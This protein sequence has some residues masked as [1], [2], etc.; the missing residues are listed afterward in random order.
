M[1]K[2]L[3]DQ[4]RAML[5]FVHVYMEMHRVAPTRQQIAEHLNY[6]DKK[7]IIPLVEELQ[8]AG[9]MVQRNGHRSDD[10]GGVYSR[11]MSPPFAQVGPIPQRVNG[12]AWNQE[13][14]FN[15]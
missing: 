5:G 14:L 6:A 13:A 12:V 11:P 2:Q 3:S 10:W 1:A 4:A 8:A 7:S 15:G 9:W